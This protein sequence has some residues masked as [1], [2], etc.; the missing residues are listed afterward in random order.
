MYDT[1]TFKKQLSFIERDILR[2]QTKKYF[3]ENIVDESKG[4][5]FTD[6]LYRTN[7]GGG[8]SICWNDTYSWFRLQRGSLAKYVNGLNIYLLEPN[9]ISLVIGYF[10]EDLGID[11]SDATVSRVD[12]AHDLILD[13]SSVLYLKFLGTARKQHSKSTW[14]TGISYELPM[15]RKLTIY[16]KIQDIIDKGKRVPSSLKGKNVLR[17]ELKTNGYYTRKSLDI[18]E[19]ILFTELGD[20]KIYG[21]FTE[22]WKNLFDSIQQIPITGHFPELFSTYKSTAHSMFNYAV[23]RAKIDGFDFLNELE[24]MV[25]AGKLKPTQKS[26]IVKKFLKIPTLGVSS[27]S[28]S[29]ELLKKVKDIHDKIV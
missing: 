15:K 4:A 7:I 5:G 23:A 12:Y 10:K 17:I 27:S 8:L 13:K 9:D 29:A 2:N 16:D 3:T 28:E 24:R 1:I 14:A 26:N 20:I 18:E 22:L 25:I 21:W 6:K 19:Q 11:I